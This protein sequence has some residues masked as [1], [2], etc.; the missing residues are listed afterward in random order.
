MVLFKVIILYLILGFIGEHNFKNGIL[1]AH[2]HTTMSYFT[3]KLYKSVQ[4]LKLHILRKDAVQPQP[5]CRFKR[6]LQYKLR[7]GVLFCTSKP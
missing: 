6:T 5:L 7:I 1:G 2:L 4:G 3:Q